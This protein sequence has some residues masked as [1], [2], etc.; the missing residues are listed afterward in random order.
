LYH[1]LS[2]LSLLFEALNQ[3]G[4]MNDYNSDLA[5]KEDVLFISLGT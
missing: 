2:S 4:A 5:E 3:L 1:P